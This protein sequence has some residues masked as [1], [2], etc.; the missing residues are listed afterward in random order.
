MHY[1]IRIDFKGFEKVIDSIGG[2]AVDV[3]RAF[4]DA[5]YPAG[6]NEFQTVHFD[7]GR[8]TMDGEEALIFAR[9]RHGDN[10]EGSDFARAARQQKILMAVRTRALSPTLI[11]N[12]ARLTGLYRSLDDSIA[13][14]MS[15]WEIARLLDIVRGI[16]TTAL[17]MN[18][19]DDAPD[20]ELTAQA[21]EDGAYVL[22]PKNGYET[23]RLAIVNAFD[24][25]ET[26]RVL[27]AR[28]TPPPPPVK[29][30][31]PPAPTVWVLNGTT[32]EGLA[33]RTG[34]VLDEQGFSVVK[35]SNAPD[36]AVTHTRVFP[37]TARGQSQ[38]PAIVSLLDPAIETTLPAAMP[39]PKD[40]DI[41]IIVG[42]D[43]STRL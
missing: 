40:I 3:E 18:V 10:G 7:T 25:T 30:D 8:Q 9:S 29:R 6:P 16:D 41:V 14:N 2:V 19:F 34:M 23:L 4:T 36:Q 17:S 24:E 5:K 37:L 42:P 33:A 13:S 21:L 26:S 1:Y 27:A 43:A 28:T 35:I 12:P 32:I 22:V 31:S 20:G 11:L 15:N 39:E 38:L